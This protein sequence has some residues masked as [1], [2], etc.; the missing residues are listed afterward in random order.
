M[1]VVWRGGAIDCSYKAAAGVQ[2][3]FDGSNQ[4]ERLFLRV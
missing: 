4:L 2:W 1:V 3:E